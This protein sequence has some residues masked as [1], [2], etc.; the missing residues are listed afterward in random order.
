MNSQ[1]V[2]H[3]YVDK[4]TLEESNAILAA[5]K[6]E[7][8]AEDLLVVITVE[9]DNHF[10]AEIKLVNGDPPYVDPVLF[11]LEGCE[12]ATASPEATTLEGTYKWKFSNDEY[13][14]HVKIAA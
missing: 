13:I 14:A 11:D 7:H 1:L 9:F 8:T 2:K 6:L 5:G 10:F 12:V 4:S 3:V